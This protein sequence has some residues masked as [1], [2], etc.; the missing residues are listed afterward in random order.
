MCAQLT[1]L[2]QRVWFECSNRTDMKSAFR[3]SR[4]VNANGMKTFCIMYRRQFNPSSP[5]KTSLR[6]FQLWGAPL[7]QKQNWWARSDPSEEELCGCYLKKTRE[8]FQWSPESWHR[9]QFGS[10]WR[11]QQGLWLGGSGR[12]DDTGSWSCGECCV[13]AG[14]VTSTWAGQALGM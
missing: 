11:E 5:I 1:A 3:I 4:L 2:E 10:T 13:C 14:T 9:A 6:A 7:I 8:P 12:T